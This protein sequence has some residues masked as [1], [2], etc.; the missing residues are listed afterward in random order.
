MG[1]VSHAETITSKQQLTAWFEEGCKPKSEWRIG[2]E[3]EKFGVIL[4][5]LEPVPYEGAVGI[6]A[7]L[8]GLVD[9]F[10]WEPVLEK[11]KLIALKQICEV[12]QASITL[13]PGGQLELSGAPLKTIHDTCHEVQIHLDQVHQVADPMGVGFIGLGFTPKWRLEE[14][15]VMPK[16]RYDIMRPY[17]QKMGTRGRDMMFRT[18]TVQVNLDFENEEDMV[19]KL[20]VALALQPL[21]TAIFANSP[22]MDGKPSGNLSE[23]AKVWHDTDPD[24]TGLMPFVFEEGMSFER[25]VDYALD[26]P[27]YFVY[28][29]GTYHNVAGLSFRDFMEGKLRGFEGIYPTLDDWSDHLTTLFPEARLK[30]FIEMRGADGGPRSRICAL[31]AFWTGLVYDNTALENALDLVKNWSP[32]TLEELRQNV[33]K[34]GLKTK[35]GAQSLKEIAGE[36][37][38]ISGAGL[39]ARGALN[40]NGED[41]T[42]FLEPVSE[43]VYSGVTGS[44]QL[45]T[46][47]TNVWGEDI[48][49]VF[50]ACAY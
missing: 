31:S 5:T 8:Q 14:C 50:K 24:R 11:G 9:Q 21:A 32:E 23:R 36:V 18:S 20:R 33:P 49:C 28:R 40:E 39:K 2:T 41:E 30:R 17:M 10:G 29:D 1:D 37:L 3:H 13:E 4:D 16:G 34:H 12:G 6:E 38:Q 43:I 27:M 15:P 45:L 47:Y 35:L 48:D 25:Y 42:M 7:L 26:V 46:L 22:F 44:E 19:K